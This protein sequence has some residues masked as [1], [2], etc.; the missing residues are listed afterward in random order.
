MFNL[1]N[2]LNFSFIAFIGCITLLGGCAGSSQIIKSSDEGNLANQETVKIITVETEGIVAPIADNILATKEQSL[3]AAKKA[4]VEKAVGV[5][6]SGQILVQKSQLIDEQIYSRTGGYIRS[7]RVISEGLDKDGLYHTK[8]TAE[9]KL[10]DVKKDI[11]AL[12]LLIKSKRVGNPRI[13][14]VISEQIDGKPADS[15]TAETVFMNVLL[16]KGYK[17]VAK[18]KIKEILDKENEDPYDNPK[19]LTK[20]GKQLDSEILIVGK[21]SSQYNASSVLEQAGMISYVSQ[22]SVKVLSNSTNEVLLAESDKGAL[23]DATKEAAVKS[24]LGELSKKVAQIIIPKIAE[25]LSESYTIVLKV[26]NI[27]D[28]N[29]IEKLRKDILYMGGV[30]SIMLRSFDEGKAEYELELGNADVNIISS[31]LEALSFWKIKVGSFT[32][33]QIEAEIK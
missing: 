27:K 33:R 23:P 9:V 15:A 29:Q 17:V 20:Y 22:L 7:W 25:K 26:K 13:I 31:K 11:D 14:V 5:Y 4:A 8:I 3:M 2:K 32:G 21:A 18:E 19:A 12:G 1:K 30:N 28:L 24:S 10:G 6:L 16:D